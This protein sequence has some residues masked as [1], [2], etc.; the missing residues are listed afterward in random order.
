MWFRMELEFGKLNK[1]SDGQMSILGRK[2]VNPKRV[3]IFGIHCVFNWGRFCHKS[4][5][6]LTF[7]FPAIISYLLI[8]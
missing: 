2:V 3:D 7:T 4:D 6:N 8:T 1:K 5:S